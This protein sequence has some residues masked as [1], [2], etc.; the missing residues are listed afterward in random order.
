MFDGDDWE[1]ERRKQARS[2][3]LAELV[4]QFFSG[5]Q[6]ISFWLYLFALGVTLGASVALISDLIGMAL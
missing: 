5:N 1:L 4:A 2:K 6:P 3:P